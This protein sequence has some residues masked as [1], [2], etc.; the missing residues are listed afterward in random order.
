MTKGGYDD[1]IVFA[2]IYPLPRLMLLCTKTSQKIEADL[3]KSSFWVEI[4]T[5]RICNL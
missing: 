5:V 1:K 3:M 2:L 4:L